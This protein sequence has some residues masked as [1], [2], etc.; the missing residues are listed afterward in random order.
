[1]WRDARKKA[2]TPAQVASPFAARPYH[3][4]HAAVSTWLNAGAPAPQAATW[5]GH[6]VDVLPRVYAKCIDGQEIR[7]ASTSN[8]RLR[9][10]RWTTSN[11]SCPRGGVVIVLVLVV[12]LSVDQLAALGVFLTVV[13]V[14]ASWLEGDRPRLLAR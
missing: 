2:L 7:R 4:R 14:A 10:R 3:L 9:Q 8:R 5:A 13:T 1:V 11:H 6:S 12:C